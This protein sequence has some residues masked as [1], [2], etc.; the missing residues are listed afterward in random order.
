MKTFTRIIYAVFGALAL[1]AG[2]VA[3]ISPGVI[4][5]PDL[6]TPVTQHLIREEAAAFVFIGMMLLWCVRHFDRRQPV[7]IGLVVF[8]GLF[9]VI[10]WLG[11]FDSGRVSLSAIANTIP[12]AIFLV[13]LPRTRNATVERPRP[14]TIA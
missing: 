9:A 12:F 10:H 1:I 13:T 14:A 5:P 3:L 11:F 2:V 8:T 4:L 7:H 6:R